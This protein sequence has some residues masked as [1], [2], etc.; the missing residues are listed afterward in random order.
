VHITE[1]DE[2]FGGDDKRNVVNRLTAGGRHGIQIEQKKGPREK[3]ARPIADA[4]ANV[5]DSE[6]GPRTITARRAV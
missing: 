1:P 5:Y 4:I 3:Y 6:L 2:L